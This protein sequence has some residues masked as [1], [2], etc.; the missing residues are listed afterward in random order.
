MASVQLNSTMAALDSTATSNIAASWLENF[1][2]FAELGDV[3]GVVSCFL[4]DGWLRDV[5][6]FNWSH[7]TFIGQEKIKDHL[8]ANFAAAKISNIALDKS[9]YFTPELAHVTPTQTAVASGFTFSTVTGTARGYFH[10]LP[11][12]QGIWKALAVF[13]IL[14][15]IH[16]HPEEARNLGF[17]EITPYPG[18]KFTGSVE[19]Q[20]RKIRIS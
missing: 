15:E 19:N 8:A 20:W 13:M 10:L 4:P 16:G 2:K 18:M 3:D 5:L 17:T 7:R 14:D 11:D 12:A 1:S 9:P 6:I